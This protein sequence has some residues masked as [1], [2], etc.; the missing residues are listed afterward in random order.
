VFCMSIL[1]GSWGLK[2]KWDMKEEGVFLTILGSKGT[3]SLDW[4]HWLI[5]SGDSFLKEWG[6][7]WS[8]WMGIALQVME[9]H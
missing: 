4:H 5:N 7:K 6:K 8:S 1:E 2:I 9:E 3:K